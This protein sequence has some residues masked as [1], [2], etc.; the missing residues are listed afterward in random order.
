MRAHLLE[1]LCREI[2]DGIDASK[3]L[4]HKQRDANLHSAHTQ[5]L[6]GALLGCCHL[7]TCTM[8]PTQSAMH[9]CTL[10]SDHMLHI[11]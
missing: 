3:L 5:Q 10:N 11:L 2:H 9:A 1:D 6:H 4:Q 8:M 7:R